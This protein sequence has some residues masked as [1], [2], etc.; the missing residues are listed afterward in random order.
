MLGF[1]CSSIVT[2]THYAYPNFLNKGINLLQMQIPN[3]FGCPF[4]F[5]YVGEDS[6]MV[7]DVVA[8]PLNPPIAPVK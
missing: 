2:I 7:D 3:Y 5:F 8:T 6:I 1:S 4:G